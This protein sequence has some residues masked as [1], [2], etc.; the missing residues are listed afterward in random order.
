MCQLWFNYW[1]IYVNVCTLD[2]DLSIFLTVKIG[3]S[4]INGILFFSWCH[5]QVN[6]REILSIWCHNISNGYLRNQVKDNI[7]FDIAKDM[8]YN[9]A[10]ADVVFA[11]WHHQM[12][13]KYSPNALKCTK[14]LAPPRGA[15]SRR[16]SN[17]P[18]VAITQTFLSQWNM[19]CFQNWISTESSLLCSQKVRHEN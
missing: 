3:H 9:E 19:P 8:G 18:E 5:F 12:K 15:K 4:W 14:R 16:S 7:W 1:V 11:N 6:M 10:V 17:A 13:I 2:L